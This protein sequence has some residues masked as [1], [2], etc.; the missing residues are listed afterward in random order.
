[1][2]RVHA[3][4]NAF[5]Q[6]KVIFTLQKKTKPS[7]DRK[8]ARYKLVPKSL[9]Y[10]STGKEWRKKGLLKSKDVE[11]KKFASPCQIT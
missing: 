7:T 4:L 11:N 9:N 3:D 5:Y 8:F 6:R 2:V 10:L 1:M